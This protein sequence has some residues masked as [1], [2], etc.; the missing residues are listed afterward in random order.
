MSS[1]GSSTSAA[2]SAEMAHAPMKPSSASMRLRSP[3]RLRISMTMA[4]V[5]GTYI[6]K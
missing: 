6:A 4:I 3:T 1:T 2:D 5:I